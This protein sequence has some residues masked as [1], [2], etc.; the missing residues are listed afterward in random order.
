MTGLQALG[1]AGTRVTDA[2]LPHLKALTGL[3]V[4]ELAGTRVTDAGC[5]A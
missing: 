2:G 1:L 3:Q 4:L 5:R